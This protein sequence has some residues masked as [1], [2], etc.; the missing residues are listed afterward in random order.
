MI[1]EDGEA[2][3]A[4]TYAWWLTGDEQSARSAVLAA[5]ERPEVPGADDQL[6]VEILLRRVRAA[7]IQAPTM[8]PASELALLHDGMGLALDSAAGL[9]SIDS[10][11]ARTELAHGRLE[12]LGPDVEVEVVEPERL[13]GLA[14]GNPADVAAARQNPKLGRLRELILQG[15]DELE[16]VTRIPVPEQL[17]ELVA[18][19]RAH[20][21]AS[22]DAD[23]GLVST[24]T[25]EGVSEVVGQ[26]EGDDQPFAGP[27]D[28]DLPGTDPEDGAE[29]TE[30]VVV[31]DASAEAL[32][33]VEA[34]EAGDDPSGPSLPTVPISL[35]DLPSAAMPGQVLDEDADADADGSDGADEDDD[36]VPV[37]AAM[38]SGDAG[39]R[40]GSGRAADDAD[41][42]AAAEEVDLSAQVSDAPPPLGRPGEGATSWFWVVVGVVLIIGVVLVLSQLGGDGEDEPVDVPTL[43]VPT[44]EDTGDGAT[45]GDTT[46]DAAS[47]VPATGDPATEDPATDAPASE[48]TASDDP[49]VTPGTDAPTDSPDGA[50]LQVLATAVSVANGPYEDTVPTAGPFDLVSFEITHEGASDGDEVQA[51]WTVDGQPFDTEDVGLLANASTARFGR[52]IPDEGWPIGTHVLDLVLPGSEE[53]LG[54]ISFIVAEEGA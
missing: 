49:V 23:G 22:Q 27:G 25:V 2:A 19:R 31:A 51:L 41:P 32:E 14:V 47:D 13:G 53:V 45:G 16:A 29:S 38:P 6:R 5:I 43:E 54:T 35:D 24:G 15:R 10:R 52:P 28:A 11:E 30:A 26:D 48:G 1:V 40:D 50:G 39:T 3:L 34:L 17:I 7:A 42:H 36:V 33:A 21:L 46:E 20:Q 44:A 37:V 9:A 12:A 8:C 4:Y 18:E